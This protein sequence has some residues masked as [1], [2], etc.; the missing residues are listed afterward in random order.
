MTRYR[1]IQIVIA[2]A[3]VGLRAHGAI[4]L[5]RHA[6]VE[7][8]STEAEARTPSSAEPDVRIAK[9]S[10]PRRFADAV[11]ASALFPVGSKTKPS[12][13]GAQPGARVKRE[14]AGARVKRGLGL[15]QKL[16]LIGTVQREHGGGEAV[17][18]DLTS[19]EQGLF[20]LHERIFQ[21]GE[22]ADIQNERILIRE[23]QQEEWLA[24]ANPKLDV[25]ALTQPSGP[26]IGETR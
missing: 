23:G 11:L 7:I 19:K 5:F 1:I 14:L 13:D 10:H 4:Q 24:T 2:G 6:P 16:H 17:V 15:S 12:P 25:T 3:V 22:L 8:A 26:Q 9:P 20:R 21:I 18:E